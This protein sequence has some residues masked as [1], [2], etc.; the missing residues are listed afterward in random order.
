M[1]LPLLLGTLLFAVGAVLIDGFASVRTARAILVLASF[2]G[3]AAVGQSLVIVMGGIDLSIPFLVG[4]ANVVGAELF[5]A[6][7]P[8]ILVVAIVIGMTAGIGAINGFLSRRFGVHPLIV[9]LGIGTDG[10]AAAL[11]VDGRVPG[12]FR[13]GLGDPRSC[14]SVPPRDPSRCRPSCCSGSPS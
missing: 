2:V 12:R 4:F 8:D 13:A 6:G 10:A 11:L 7:I 14:P 1:A 9:T 5:D 3:I